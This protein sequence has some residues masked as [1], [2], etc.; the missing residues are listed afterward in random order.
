MKIALPFHLLHFVAETLLKKARKACTK[1]NFLVLLNKSMR[2]VT[3]KPV[4]VATLTGHAAIAVDMFNAQLAPGGQ[5]TPHQINSYA[6]TVIAYDGPRGIH[7]AHVLG[8]ASTDNASF[9]SGHVIAYRENALVD[10]LTLSTD[11][12]HYLVLCE[13]NPGKGQTLDDAYFEKKLAD[14]ATAV[15]QFSTAP[16]SFAIRDDSNL[17]DA[18]WREELGPS[19]SAGVMRRKRGPSVDYFIMANCTAET[20]GQ[21][22]ID[23]ITKLKEAG[24]QPTWR[25]AVD[26]MEFKYWQQGVRRNA[27]RIAFAVA[28][29]LKVSINTI[30]EDATY[31]QT[32]DQARHQTALP[33]HAQWISS[34][35]RST[36]PESR[37][38]TTVS[39]YSKCAPVVRRTNEIGYHLVTLFFFL[40]ESLLTG[41]ECR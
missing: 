38:P 40:G 17:D 33:T 20:L 26:S 30:G 37:V 10:P 41:W 11:A 31:R 34:I 21:N 19:G 4:E 7:S 25:E 12:M 28:E 29:K 27:A 24:K 18:L 35:A 23:H 39:Q 9:P 14:L 2:A 5:L 22:F 16:I 8:N 36:P 15:P 6:E 3:A 1:R 32:A 13:I